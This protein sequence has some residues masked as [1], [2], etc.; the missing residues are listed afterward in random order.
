MKFKKR[1]L[2]TLNGDLAADILD[3][4]KIVSVKFDGMDFLVLV[5]YK[6]GGEWAYG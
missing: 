6:R 2:T 1:K 4:A 3:G 5:E